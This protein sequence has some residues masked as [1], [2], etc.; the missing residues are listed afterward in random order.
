MSIMERLDDAQIDMPFPTQVLLMQEQTE[1][2]TVFEPNNAI[3]GTGTT[4][5][6]TV[7]LWQVPTDILKSGL[8]VQRKTTIESEAMQLLTAKCPY[9]G[10]DVETTIDHT[11]EPIVCPKCQKPF[12]MEIPS[13]EVTSVR[14]VEVVKTQ[15]HIA[16]KPKEH[17]LHRVHPVVFRARPLGSLIVLTVTVAAVYGLWLGLTMEDSASEGKLLGS[18]TLASINWLL[19]MSVAALIFVVGLL[20]YWFA[21]SMSTTLTVT[22]SRTI[23]K[24]GIF[25]RDTSEVQHDDV[26]NIQIDQSLFERL[27]RIGEIGIA[28]SGQDELEIVASRI[29]SPGSITET[30]RQNQRK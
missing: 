17:T 7:D 13:A 24:R 22:D 16:T 23:F 15:D 20:S 30:I 26:R 9:C 1:A 19:W 4:I 14:E 18:T 10:R 12:E 28:S 27:L 3:A 11:A 29:P 8:T 6:S 5:P 25:S 2:L 21:M